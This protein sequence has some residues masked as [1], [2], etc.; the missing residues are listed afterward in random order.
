MQKQKCKNIQLK[1]AWNKYFEIDREIL[2]IF[3][4]TALN[5]LT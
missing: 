1:R 2:Q 3:Q 4:S 5:S